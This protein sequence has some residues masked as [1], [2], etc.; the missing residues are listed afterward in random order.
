MMKEN[1]NHYSCSNAESYRSNIC[2]N[3][4]PIRM[5]FE[6]VLVIKKEVKK[7]KY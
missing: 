7:R 6:E 4:K 3:V 1:K 2:Y 5:P